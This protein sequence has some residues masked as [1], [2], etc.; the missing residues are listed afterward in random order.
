M[1]SAAWA[2]ARARLG[3]TLGAGAAI[4][5]GVATAVYTAAAPPNPAG[6][7]DVQAIAPL[8]PP[9]VFALAACATLLSFRRLAA[10]DPRLNPIERRA[11]AAPWGWLNRAIF[12]V[13]TGV[14]AGWT[15]H[16]ILL[17][18]G[19][20]CRDATV[21]RPQA[22]LAIGLCGGLTAAAVA[23]ASADI[24]PAGLLGRLA[25]LVVAGLALSMLL[26]D[27]PRWWE[28][29]LSFMGRRGPSARVFNVTLVIAGLGLWGLML[30]IG[31]SL[32]GLAEAG[33]FPPQ[34]AR[35]LAISL[36]VASIGLMGI[37]VFPDAT[38]LG[39]VLHKLTGHGALLIFIA[40]MLGLRWLAPPF[41]RTAHRA[42]ALLGGLCLFAA[43]LNAAQ[44]LNYVLFEL[45]VISLL[46]VWLFLYQACAGAYVRDHGRQSQADRTEK[47]GAP[48]A[49]AGG[50]GLR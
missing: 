20:A 14:L 47:I 25:A 48:P 32:S 37:G 4:A 11:S 24:G 18:I 31:R 46:F 3:G 15:A 23:F 9:L 45:A 6:L 26:V 7:F 36:S 34:G 39:A 28:D 27:D 12:S 33:Q 40:V 49:Q 10:Q 2:E 16:L 50:N 19:P 17:A 41:G 1:R 13:L 42:S 44:A 29:S 5:S 43:A 8:L 35:A 22:I 21:S 30:E 38:P